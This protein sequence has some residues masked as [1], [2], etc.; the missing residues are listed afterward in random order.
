MPAAWAN[1]GLTTFVCISNRVFQHGNLSRGVCPVAGYSRSLLATCGVPRAFGYYLADCKITAT[2]ALSLGL[3]HMVRNG[4]EDAKRHAER[5]ASHLSV[6]PAAAMVKGRGGINW[7]LLAAEAVAHIECQMVN[8]GLRLEPAGQD[9]LPRYQPLPEGTPHAT[10]TSVALSFCTPLE[11]MPRGAESF[12]RRQH[13]GDACGVLLSHA[14]ADA[15]GDAAR[16][17]PSIISLVPRRRAMAHAKL[18]A[19][20]VSLDTRLGVARVE[21]AGTLDVPVLGLMAAVA[22]LQRPWLVLRAVVV[23]LGDRFSQYLLR[24]ARTS[25]Q[26]ERAVDA[27]HALGVPIVCCTADSDY[28]LRSGLAGSS[29][30]AVATKR[31][32][33]LAGRLVH[34][35]AIGKRHML[36]LMRQQ[37]HP[38]PHDALLAVAATAAAILPLG[39]R[40]ET[41]LCFAEQNVLALAA[42][43]SL[44]LVQYGRRCTLSMLRTE[45]PR[46]GRPTVGASK[47]V[48]THALEVYTP[49]HCANASTVEIRDGISGPHARGR[50]AERYSACGED[51]DAASMA[52]TVC[53]RLMRRCGVRLAGVGAL[54]VSATL[55]D[56]SKSMKTELSALIEARTDADTEGVDHCGDSAGRLSALQSCLSWVKN[57]CWDGRWGVAVLALDAP[58]SPLSSSSAA[59]A[60]LVGAQLRVDNE[61]SIERELP[62]LIAGLQMAPLVAGKR[63]NVRAFGDDGGLPT[64]QEARHLL[65]AAAFAVV[66]ARHA[67]T[68]AVFGR[69]AP[70]G[71]QTG[72]ACYLLEAP[73]PTRDGAAGRRY[74]LKELAG[75][76]HAALRSAAATPSLAR[77]DSPVKGGS[78]EQLAHLLTHA[79]APTTTAVAN[80]MPVHAMTVVREVAS[81]LLP[82]ASADAPLMEAGLDSLGAV[83]LRNRLAARLGDAAELPDT[84]VFDFPT[85]RQIEAHLSARIQSKAA[86]VA[87]TVPVGGANM[88]L[89]AQLL[90]SLGMSSAPASSPAVACLVDASVVVRE[91]A[92]ELLPSASADA[93]LMEAGLDSLGAVE[94]RNRLAARLGDAAELPDTLVF[95][96]PTLRQIEAHLS[97]RI[98]SKAAPVASTVPVGGANMALLA[99]LLNS[100]G[101]SSAPASSPAVACLVDASVVV[102]EVAS[103]LLPRVS[104]DAPLMEA[105]LDSLGAV[106]LR[107]RLTARFGDAVELPETLVFDFPTLRQ[108]EAH[109]TT[110]V[111]PAAPAVLAVSPTAAL[112]RRLSHGGASA[113][114]TAALAL[115]GACCQLPRGLTSMPAL[116]C[117]AAAAYDTVASVPTTRWDAADRPS[118]L[119]VRV[120]DRTCHGAF[121]FG[122]E[123][124]DNGRF[125]ISSAEARA[126]DPQQR[127]LLE[128]GYVSLHTSGSNRATLNGSGT[129]VALGIYATEFARLLAGSPLGRSVYATS[130]SLSIA[131]GRVSFALGLQGPCTSFETACSASLVACHSA[132]RALQHA[133]C[134]PHLAAGVNLMLLQASSVGMA[135]AGMT[136]VA[137]RCHTFDRRADGFARSEGLSAAVVRI[138]DDRG[139]VLLRGSAVRQD[140][141]SASLTA[142][143]GQAQQGL[144]RGA[145]HDASLEACALSLHETHGTGTALGDPI[146]AGSLAAA[147]LAQQRPEDVLVCG[148]VK[149]NL[150]H[151]E[152]TAGV[153]GLLRLALGLAS[154]DAAP[155]AQLR[156]LNPHVGGALRD[157]ICALAAQPGA[158]GVEGGSGGVSSFGYSGTIVHALLAS[159][160]GHGGAALDFGPV[161]GS[162]LRTKVMY[163]RCSFLWC[164]P[165][166]AA[167]QFPISTPASRRIHRRVMA[168]STLTCQRRPSLIEVIEMAKSTTNSPLD[169]DDTFMDAGLDSHGAI[170]FR[171]LVQNFAGIELPDTLIFDCP[172]ARKLAAF[173]ESGQYKPLSTSP[174]TLSRLEDPAGVAVLTG[175][176]ARQP[177][178]VESS[179][180]LRL[181]TECD[182]DAVSEVPSER[183]FTDACSVI[184]PNSVMPDLIANRV[185]HGGFVEGLTLFDNGH[186]RISPAEAASMDPQQRLVLEHGYAALQAAGANRSTLDESVAGVFIGVQ[187]C[188][189]TELLAAMSA[190]S[191]VSAPCPC[192]C[193]CAMSCPC[194]MSVSH[195]LVHVTCLRVYV[196]IV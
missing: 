128:G 195:V 130:T 151:G 101:M 67:R 124:F 170:E 74:C 186:F 47:G 192:P 20:Q 34:H 31:A 58:N 8:G 105:G 6:Q 26:M 43:R 154:G 152:S 83:E 91:V 190:S 169:A 42:P 179:R 182:G 15:N 159:R 185:R 162:R 68:S 149:A 45:L 187:A 9:A 140:G 76:E 28:A 176:S 18:G 81:E 111:A 73:T 5:L 16:V 127:V 165:P 49:R 37:L 75:V 144:L 131:S 14:L 52:L 86:P 107:N 93:P 158:L 102:N 4:V 48:S 184:T 89:L 92:S 117:A 17:Q 155:N 56:R 44:P 194:P 65:D 54:H 160:R 163:R 12:G 27:L 95:D 72:N 2:D 147:V 78:N 177:R 94:L 181:M 99:Q 167:E 82:S 79:A 55:L 157:V 104:A 41:G 88:A 120:A 30:V 112:P 114:A 10:A 123:A 153:S 98:Q 115:T 125:A 191:R 113:A 96:F 51:E 196:I 150:G 46:P 90:N 122:A 136:S 29:A 106:E 138:C 25:E 71:P 175:L 108:I 39:A 24:T 63:A 35:P 134:S 183:W 132:V 146:E 66:R 180:A 62:R 145:L 19:A 171:H 3:V 133:E 87:S 97:A 116:G 103:E 69:V 77:E 188:E 100:L 85:L 60:V 64:P 57:G 32:D 110:L 36:S 135:I 143:N 141:R 13:V 50:L 137:G 21:I 164:G 178:G 70:A 193:P 148:G 126:M 22:C 139:R 7:Q 168:E 53:V 118:E 174:A 33:Q 121:I 84:L 166:L 38:R 80:S 109:V 11:W 23:R 40:S 156:A 61:K 1:S 142:P 119:D 59:T 129:G 189:F 173:L 172:T 161:D